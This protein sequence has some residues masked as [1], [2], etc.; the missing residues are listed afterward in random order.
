M[1]FYNLLKIG[2]IELKKNSILNYNL[3]SEIL[4]SQALNI[5]RENLILNLNKTV[6]KFIQQKYF[7]LIKN[8]L[9]KYL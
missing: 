9:K 7:N 6:N 3:D 8:G 2:K 5:S 1:N 4:L